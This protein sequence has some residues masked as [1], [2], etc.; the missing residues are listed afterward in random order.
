MVARFLPLLLALAAT[1]AAWAQAPLE[2]EPDGP[3]RKNQKVE[4][5]RHEDDANVIE[6]VRVGGQVQSV[7]VQP[8]GNMPPYEMQPSDLAR[9]RPAD[10]RDGSM[11]G[12]QRVWNFLNF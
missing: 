12:T 8:K 1:T 11:G 9:T 6:E 7:T 4:R 10:R 2:R 3:G 5:L